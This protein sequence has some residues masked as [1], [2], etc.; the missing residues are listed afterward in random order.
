M[1]PGLF[2]QEYMLA[3]KT[4]PGR[5]GRRQLWCR[6]RFLPAGGDGGSRLGVSGGW[7]QDQCRRCPSNAIPA[8][9]SFDEVQVY[10]FRGHRSVWGCFLMPPTPRYSSSPNS[11]VVPCESPPLPS[12]RAL[13]PSMPAPPDSRVSQFPEVP[14]LLEHLFLGEH[15]SSGEDFSLEL[16]HHPQTLLTSI[17]SL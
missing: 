17:I 6:Q 4:L 16:L 2:R 1:S 13:Q 12:P 10:T 14:D 5:A 11:A 8:A 9:D 15:P 7:E 3:A